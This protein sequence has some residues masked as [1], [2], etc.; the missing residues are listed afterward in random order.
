MSSMMPD[1][2][3]DPETGDGAE[4]LADPE[5]YNLRRRLRQLHDAKQAVIDSK[6]RAVNATVIEESISKPQRDRIVA[7]KLIDYVRELRPV[8]DKRTSD[9]DHKETDAESFLEEDVTELDGETITLRMI[10]DQHGQ[11]QTENNEGWIPY[12]VSMMAW[13]CCNTYFEEIGGAVFE[14]ESLP[15]DHGFDATRE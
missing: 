11:I 15:V 1:Q 13:D 6:D 2:T 4:R 14:T 5:D 12:Q 10:V 7:E 3:G 8:L 9:T